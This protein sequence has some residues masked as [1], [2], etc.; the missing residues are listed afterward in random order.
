MLL[1]IYPTLPQVTVSRKVTYHGCMDILDN[2][3]ILAQRDPETALDVIASEWEQVLLDLTINNAPS[4]DMQVKHVVVAGMGGSGLASDMLKDWLDLPVPYEVVKGYDLPSYVSQET[5]VVVSSFS[6]NTE[7]TLST[8][9]QALEAKAQVVVITKGGKLLERAKELELP[10]VQMEWGHQ[11]R[12]GMFINLN[13]L[14][15]LL[16][17]YGV[18]SSDAIEELKA[19]GTWLHE[20]SQQ[21]LKEVPYQDN[22]AKQLA[23][24][25]AGKTPV[26]YAGTHI[27]SLAYKWKISFNENSKNVAFHN[28]YPEFNHNEFIGWSSHPVEKPFAIILL[29]SSFDHERIQKRFDLSE[30]LLSGKRPAARSIDL[31]GDTRLQQ[32]LWGAVF[33]DFTSAYLGILNGVDPMKVELVEK[34]K[35]EMG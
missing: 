14:V 25:C 31:K 3:Q 13:A 29:K 11:P 17:L 7:E 9:D 10:F 1:L 35:L 12:M 15:R 27:K 32:M 19:T 6:G 33:A 24:W 28:E 4:V 8:L 22:Q 30:K 16:A 5:L 34:L 2:A 20:A 18:V 26:C 23:G 21:W